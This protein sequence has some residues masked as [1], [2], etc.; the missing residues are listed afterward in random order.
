MHG[1][2]DW[3]HRAGPYVDMCAFGAHILTDSAEAILRYVS[4]YLCNVWLNEHIGLLFTTTTTPASS[5]MHPHSGE[6]WATHMTKNLHSTGAKNA[7][8]NRSNCVTREHAP[9]C[10][11]LKYY[12]GQTFFKKLVLH[13]VPI[14]LSNNEFPHKL[15]VWLLSK[16]LTL[17]QY[18]AYTYIAQRLGSNCEIGWKG[19]W[20]EERVRT[21][22][23]GWK[24]AD[25]FSQPADAIALCSSNPLK[26]GRWV[27]SRAGSPVTAMWLCLW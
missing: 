24:S 20:Y 14:Y 13:C 3:T 26:S 7:L 4:K 25:L 10:F 23:P 17:C 22:H 21:Q 12:S 15:T 18:P 5:I 2:E 11:N 8:Q 27:S 1:E 19:R 6:A 16:C 9:I